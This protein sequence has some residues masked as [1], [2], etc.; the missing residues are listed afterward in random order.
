MPDRDIPC[1]RCEEEKR[2][3]ELGGIWEVVSCKP[4]TYRPGRCKIV[5]RVKKKPQK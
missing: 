1:D 4:V 2:R 3:L 5:Y